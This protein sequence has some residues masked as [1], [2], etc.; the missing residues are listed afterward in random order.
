MSDFYIGEIRLFPMNYAPKY[1]A[2]CDGQIMQASQ[3][4]ALISLL[5]NKFGGDGRTTFGLPD[6]RGR[7]PLA[8]ST[9]QPLPTPTVYP[10][11]EN[12]GSETVTLQTTQM[13]PHTHA[14]QAANTGSTTTNGQL[15]TNTTLG[16]PVSKTAGV[17]PFNIYG[18]A[19][20][21]SA[22]D[23]GSITVSGGGGGHSNMQPFLAVNFCIAISGLYPPRQ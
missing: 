14:L 10:W 1:W 6:L 18:P 22:I 19:Q 13:P 5:G 23:A 11:G 16:V 17:S 3:N 4:Q 8:M 12:G 20:N 7:V 9:R 21:L 2:Q 15:P